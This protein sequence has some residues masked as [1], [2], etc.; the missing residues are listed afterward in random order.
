MTERITS[1]LLSPWGF[2][3]SLPWVRDHPL[4]V[5]VLSGAS[6][7]LPPLVLV[8]SAMMATRWSRKR[9]RQR[10]AAER[11]A[12]GIASLSDMPESLLRTLAAEVGVREARLLLL[13]DI[14]ED[15]RLSN[16]VLNDIL[17]SGVIASTRDAL[18]GTWD[19]YRRCEFCLRY[20]DPLFVVFNAAS[21]DDLFLSSNGYR[22]SGVIPVVSGIGETSDGMYVVVRSAP[23]WTR[24]EWDD[25]VDVLA[26]GLDAPDLRVELE[27]VS[28]AII[29]L[30]DARLRPKHTPREKPKADSDEGTPPTENTADTEDR[31]KDPKQ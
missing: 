16:L 22:L 18:L 23:D 3:E 7:V 28:S 2:F 6:L 20:R 1:W 13:Q 5:A 8:A 27:G 21:W 11:R 29:H 4:L 14:A 31:A 24:N 10:E 9:R 15:W 17:D 30:N 26:V 25:V 19:S 12:K